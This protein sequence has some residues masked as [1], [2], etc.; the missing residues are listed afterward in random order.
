MRHEA[1]PEQSGRALEQVGRHTWV[2]PAVDPARSVPE[3][4][5]ALRRAGA[6]EAADH[7]ERRIARRS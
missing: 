1:P 4:L 6:V 3:T 5:A 2:L 7:L